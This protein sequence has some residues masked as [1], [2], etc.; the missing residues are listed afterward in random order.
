ME[1]LNFLQS[2]RNEVKGEIRQRVDT[3]ITKIR[4][5]LGFDPG[6]R[7]IVERGPEGRKGRKALKS[8]LEE[9]SIYLV[10]KPDLVARNL[11]ILSV[12]D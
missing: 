6:F 10:N 3:Q 7:K 1:V 12:V 11:E 2:I 4:L 8:L 9:V 5:F